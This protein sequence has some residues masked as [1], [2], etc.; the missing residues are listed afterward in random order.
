LDSPA[1]IRSARGSSSRLIQAAASPQAASA[2]S[3]SPS[4][5]SVNDPFPSVSRPWWASSHQ[6]VAQ[7]IA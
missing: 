1:A 7:R 3:V 6:P 5:G 2:I 4:G